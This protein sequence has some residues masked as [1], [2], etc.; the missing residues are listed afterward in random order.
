MPPGRILKR[1]IIRLET[2]LPYAASWASGGEPSGTIK[3]RSEVDAVVLMYQA[4]S[5]LAAGWKSIDQRVPITLV[6]TATLVVAGRGLSVP[7]VATH[8]TAGGGVAVL[9]LAGDC[10]RAES[11]TGWLYQPAGRVTVSQPAQGAEH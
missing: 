6:R 4:R 8:N 11:A 1:S 3:V 2:P 9:Y 10:S 7:S 5:F